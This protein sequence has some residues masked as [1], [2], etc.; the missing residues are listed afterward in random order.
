MFKSFLSSKGDLGFEKLAQEYIMELASCWKPV[1]GT[2]PGL[3]LDRE[4]CHDFVALET[5]SIFKP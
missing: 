2:Y 5:L 4:A 3:H 1:A